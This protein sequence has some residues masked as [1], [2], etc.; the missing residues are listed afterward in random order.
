MKWQKFKTTG[1][2]NF[3]PGTIKVKD[4]NGGLQN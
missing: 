1:G 3:Y 2:H 4:Q